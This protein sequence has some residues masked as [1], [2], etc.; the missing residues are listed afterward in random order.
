MK[1]LALASLAALTTLA[2]ADSNVALGKT[3]TAVDSVYGADLST[4]TDG[5]YLAQGTGWTNGTIYWYGTA[6]ALEIDLAGTFT[7]TKMNVQADDNDNYRIDYF[8]GTSWATAWDVP[9]ADV[10][11][12]QNVAGM[13]T[14]PDPSDNSALFT[15]T[16]PVTATK[17]RLVAD[18]GAGIGDGYY[19]A[20]ELQAYGEPVPEPATL[21]VLGLGA[22]CAR[23]R[24]LG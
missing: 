19:S 23:Q 10:V 15:L 11:N 24:R 13:Q 12:N 8:D 9:N 14:R 1:T 6:P 2:V 22:L 20:S 17:L 4:L 3:V 7:I 16:A 5:N 18:P 21:L